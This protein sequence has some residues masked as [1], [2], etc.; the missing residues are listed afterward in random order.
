VKPPVAAV[1]PAGLLA[2]AFSLM[3]VNSQR[4]AKFPIQNAQFCDESTTAKKVKCRLFSDGPTEILSILQ[5]ID[6]R[7]VLRAVDWRA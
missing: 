3:D 4:N 6:D 2:T 5:D 1:T 7:I